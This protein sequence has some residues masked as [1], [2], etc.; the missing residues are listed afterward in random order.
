MRL[1]GRRAEREALGDLLNSVR[2]GASR[3]AVIRGDPGAGK[4]ALLQYAVDAAPD[5]Q[6]VRMAAVEPEQALAFA[7]VHQLLLPLAPGADRLPDPQRRALQVAFGELNG[8]PADRFLVGLAVLTLLSQSAE[9]GPLLCVIDDAQWLDDESANVFCFVARRLLADPVGILVAV[10]DGASAHAALTELPEIR[11][12]GLSA[13]DAGEL[14][15]VQTGQSVDGAVTEQLVAETAGN[16]LALIGAAR[17]LSRGQLAGRTP[18]PEPL[19]IG[20]QLEESF[21]RRMGE[22]SADTRTLLLLAAA[23]PPGRPDRLWRAAAAL[24]I[25]ES[26]AVAVEGAGIAVFWPEVRFSHPLARSAVYAAATSLERRQAHRTL[27]A[28]SNEETDIDIRAWHLAAAAAGPDEEA[29]A[30]QE[31][32]AE[33]AMD[34]GGYGAA[35]TLLERAALLTA[36]PDRRAERQLSAAQ[37]EFLTGMVGRADELLDHAI[38]GLRD[39]LSQ[40]QATRLRGRI[41]Y[42]RGEVAD[43]TATLTAAAQRLQGLAPRAARDGLLSALEAAVFAGWDA[44]SPLLDHIARAARDLPPF[45]EPT[46]SPANLLLQGFVAR[47]ADGYAV[48]VP[49]LRRAVRAFS[50]ER[51]DPN[52]A[53]Q[54]AELVAI[55]AIDLLDDAAVEVLIGRWIQRAREAG[56]L[57]RLAAGLAFRS[58]FVDGPLGRLAAARAAESEAHELRQLTGNPAVVPPT[59]AHTLLTVALAGQEAQARATAAAVAR[60]APRRGAVGEMALA[61]SSLA[62]LELGLGNYEAAV[63]ALLPA[64]TDDTPLVGTR[65]LPDLVEAAARAGKHSL[66]RQV[67]ARFEERARATGTPL[68]LG[69]LARSRA[70]LAAP[71]RAREDYEEA[72]PLLRQTGAGPQIARAHLLYGEWLRRQRRRREA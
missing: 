2:A 49:V 9:S 15:T 36:E 52:L 48:A 64:W 57:A 27:A 61:T 24:A 35:A 67:L 41:Q 54:R 12:G 58:V 14:L 22:L 18:L 1:V 4:S 26:A 66:A 65:A 38:P 70:L 56:A 59:G 3:A 40:A 29:A 37:A 7:A 69:L 47:V 63:A 32:A 13:R 25:P 34:R 21:A 23:D 53:L 6:I 43:A 33:R 50:S 46:D 72:L 28:A 51:T 68:A 17:H 30:A 20:H 55:A 71:D 39:P 8:P 60:E 31:A 19:P 62:I 45:G 5:M 16:P 44:T 11:L 10:E 42:T